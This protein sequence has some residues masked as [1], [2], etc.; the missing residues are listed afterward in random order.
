[1]IKDEEYM[2]FL[3]YV[4]WQLNHNLCR[5]KVLKTKTAFNS[6][7]SKLGFLYFVK[8]L[9]FRTSTNKGQYLSLLFSRSVVFKVDA[10]GPY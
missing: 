7:W 10:R 4:D 6:L 5:K 3:M 8:Y 1:M 2:M 9:Q